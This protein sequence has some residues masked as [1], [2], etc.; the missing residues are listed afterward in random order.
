M[1]TGGIHTPRSS[2]NTLLRLGS[3]GW[4]FSL[5]PFHSGSVGVVGVGAFFDPVRT[6]GPIAPTARF[7]LVGAWGED[8]SIR[9][10]KSGQGNVALTWGIV[11]AN[12]ELTSA[13]ALKYDR[14][15]PN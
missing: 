15:R 12:A 6:H 14:A 2:V 1:P 11:M 9:Q 7:Q 8:P 5:R 3:D 10:A 4:F 13:Q